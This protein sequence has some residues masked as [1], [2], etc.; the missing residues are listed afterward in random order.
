MQCTCARLLFDTACKYRAQ[1]R[2]YL[3]TLQP[4]PAANWPLLRSLIVTQWHDSKE[5]GRASA[6]GC[7]TPASRLPSG[8]PGALQRLTRLSLPG[9]ST[10][11]WQRRS[12]RH[13]EPRFPPPL[14]PNA[15]TTCVDG[16]RPTRVLHAPSRAPPASTGRRV[17]QNG[18]EAARASR[19]RLSNLGLPSPA[20][21]TRSYSPSGGDGSEKGTFA[22]AAYLQGAGHSLVPLLARVIVELL[23]CRPPRGTSLLQGNQACLGASAYSRQLPHCG[24]L[25]NAAM[26]PSTPASD[27]VFGHIELV[28]AV[29]ASLQMRER[30]ACS[31]I[32]SVFRMANAAINSFQDVSCLKFRGNLCVYSCAVSD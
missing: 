23:F 22:A 26:E 18:W 6:Q 17:A 11:E 10:Q 20:H 9:V 28:S 2:Q 5:A 24:T 12:G 27:A 1:R 3:D 13:A 7:R 14:L 19:Q 29:L 15:A 4:G 31:L 16:R 25:A 21:R 32:S 30:L 8:T